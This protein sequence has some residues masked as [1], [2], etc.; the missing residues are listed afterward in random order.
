MKSK[1]LASLHAAN[2]MFSSCLKDRV[3]KCMNR[4]ALNPIGR[5]RMAVCEWPLPVIPQCWKQRSL[6]VTVTT[7]NKL[8]VTTP[9]QQGWSWIILSSNYSKST[10]S[11]ASLV[12]LQITSTAFHC[13]KLLQIACFQDWSCGDD[14]SPCLESWSN[15]IECTSASPEKNEG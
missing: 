10:L 12:A 2:L 6:A 4:S 7:H 9:Q 8:Y 5:I 3:I 11:L 14:R 13:S 1:Y 15:D